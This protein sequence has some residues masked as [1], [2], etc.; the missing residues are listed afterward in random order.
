MTKAI[1][2]IMDRKALLDVECKKIYTNYS[3][4]Q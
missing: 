1:E 3:V 4:I 2:N